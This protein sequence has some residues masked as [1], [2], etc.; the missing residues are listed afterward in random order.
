MS[1]TQRWLQHL[2][3]L[4]FVAEVMEK[5]IPRTFITKD[6]WG[7]D[8]LAAKPGYTRSCRHLVTRALGK[9]GLRPLVQLNEVPVRAFLDVRAG[10]EDLPVAISAHDLRR[11][12]S[13]R[14]AAERQ[15][16][17]NQGDG[18]LVTF[19]H[20]PPPDCENDRRLLSSSGVT[21]R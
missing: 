9:E 11:L 17:E 14:C 2:R 18:Y 1:P 20:T 15:A 7:A 21:G 6:L 4:A 13:G 3:S 8:I 19:A 12:L 5:R 10:V 16:H